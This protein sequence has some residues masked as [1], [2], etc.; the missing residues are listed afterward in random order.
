MRRTTTTGR[1]GGH[2]PP[3]RRGKVLVLF[4]VLLPALVAV[5]GLVVDSGILMAHSRDVQNV[6]DAAATAAARVLLSGGT[7]AAA[8][9]KANECAA[10]TAGP[11]GAQVTVN[12]P[13]TQG[14]FAGV[15]G[16][17]EVVARRSATTYVTH[18]LGNSTHTLQS[19]AV[20]G[21]KTVTNATA[22]ITLDPRPPF[23][24][25]PALSYWTSQL[26][27][28]RSAVEIV[29]PG[30]LEVDGALLSNAAL[31]GLD[32]AGQPVG[33]GAGGPYGLACINSYLRVEDLRICGGVSDPTRLEFDGSGRG[34]QAG[35]LPVP[36]PLASLPLPTTTADPVNVVT[37]WRGGRRV[38]DS[39]SDKTLS[40]GVYDWIDVDAD[41]AYFRPG[42]YIIRAV[43]SNTG[44][45]LRILG[46]WVRAEGVMFY[47]T[48][49]S[50]YSATSGSP[51]GTLQ[52]AAWESVTTQT[53][54][55]WIEIGLGSRFMGIS[56]SASPFYR[57][58]VFQARHDRRPMYITKL[59]GGDEYIFGN[60]YGKWSRAY[61][62]S[63]SRVD[64]RLV[65]GSL[66][67]F[68]QSDSRLAPP[69]RLP[70]ARDVFLVE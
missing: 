70:A 54:G 58:L 53:P 15:A 26:P 16:Y 13:P 31:G 33:I 32:A 6:A 37:N 14:A 56:D 64:C 35:R 44:L 62:V 50:S 46:D 11:L 47:I 34:L 63:S 52:P 55:V 51:D 19:R 23:A 28:P 65:V 30:R 7:T 57:V 17:V 49:S 20:A 59:L 42:V 41:S 9:A 29:G 60:I 25:V 38:R 22:A 39:D 5:A 43:D 66:T 67:W 48:D 2:Q 12:I 8:T 40:P 3:T 18:G 36:D 24:N 1:A 69:N 27:T 45:A 68:S 4:A 21:A 61:V 10:A